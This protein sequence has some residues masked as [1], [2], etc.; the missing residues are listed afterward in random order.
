M[1]KLLYTLLSTLMLV[2]F[3]TTSCDEEALDVPPLSLTELDYFSTEAEFERAVIGLYARLTDFYWYRRGSWQNHGAYH[4]PG[5]DITVTGGGFETFGTIQPGNGDLQYIY[6]R[7]YQVIARANV[8][9]QKFEQEDGVYTDATLKNHHKG[10]VLFLRAWAYWRLW[11]YFGTPPL[12][13]ERIQ[14]TDKIYPPNSAENELLDQAILDLQ[15]AA[16]L[17]PDSWPAEEA[18]KVFKSSANGLLGKVLVFRG[19]VTGNTSDFQA[20]LTAFNAITDRSLADNFSDNFN[21]FT[22]NNE[23]SLFEE[24]A[25]QA[26]GFDN[27]WLENDF[28]NAVGS[29]S[30]FWGFYEGGANNGMFGAALYQATP[31]LIATY[32]PQDPRRIHYID[33]ENN[34]RKYGIAE[35]TGY[36]QSGANGSL[37]NPRIL[38]YADVLLLEAEAI[39]RTGGSTAEAIGLI[40]EVR[41]RAR[42]WGIAEG[43]GDG[44]A[45]ADRPVITDTDMVLEW[46]FEE[47]YLE[48]AGEESHRWWDLK[49]R[50]AAGEIDLANFD[51]SS[52]AAGFSFDPEVHIL[53]PIPT[54]ETDLNPNI[55]QNH[56]Y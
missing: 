38:R 19:T 30:A 17:L 35:E 50:H 54:N 39:I 3:V 45:P 1:K 53:F 6:G 11:N 10:Q 46:I 42:E 23:E 12:I 13:T 41:T 26:I 31:K 27:V 7:F 18:G 44:T 40:N 52:I 36:P 25:S 37:N 14:T 48:L 24:Q 29:I 51:F 15:E 16:G 47:R 33:E 4:L 2:L 32:D 8:L 5:D 34:F 49:R 55:V 28:D 22:E 56:G 21:A 43:I 20:A 9:L